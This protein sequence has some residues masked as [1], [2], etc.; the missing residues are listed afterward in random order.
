MAHDH[1]GGLHVVP[2]VD[3]GSLHGLDGYGVMDYRHGG[4]PF[5][6]E[7]DAGR[8]VW[9]STYGEALEWADREMNPPG[10][11]ELGPADSPTSG[12]RPSRWETGASPR[13]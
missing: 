6:V 3:P 7:G 2:R 9:F 1:F 13:W 10:V 11:T 12:P 5:W 4:A 8:P